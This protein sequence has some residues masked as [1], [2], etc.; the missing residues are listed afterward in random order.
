MISGSHDLVLLKTVETEI[1]CFINV[2]MALY[3]NMREYQD[4]DQDQNQ[5]RAVDIKKN[6]SLEFCPNS[7]LK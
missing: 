6:I 5:D 3:Q 1:S 4:Q 2:T 7:F